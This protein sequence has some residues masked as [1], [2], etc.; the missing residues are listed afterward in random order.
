MINKSYELAKEIYAAQ[1]ID[2][3]AAIANAKSLLQG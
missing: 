1:G 2:T 3:D